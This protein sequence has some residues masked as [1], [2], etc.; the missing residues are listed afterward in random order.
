[1]LR[2]AL[3]AA[4]AL[5]NPVG[6]VTHAQAALALQPKRKELDKLLLR[7]Q[8]EEAQV[9]L[10]QLLLACVRAIGDGAADP[11]LP[12]GAVNRMADVVA[13]VDAARAVAD[14]PTGSNAAASATLRKGIARLA[15]LLSA[16]VLCRDVFVA[17][18]GASAILAS[19]AEDNVAVLQALKAS[20]HGHP[21]GAEALSTAATQRQGAGAAALAGAIRDRRVAVICG[22][23]DV[24]T[25]AAKGV[26]SAVLRGPTAPV[27]T[28]LLMCS[29]APPAV[30]NRAAALLAACANA[31]PKMLAS[32]LTAHHSSLAPAAS[33]I[34]ATC[35]TAGCISG[36]VHHTLQWALA[37]A[38]GSPACARSLAASE[39]MCAALLAVLRWDC[40]AVP[41]LDR[42]VFASGSAIVRRSWARAPAETVTRLRLA[43]R[44]STRLVTAIKQTDADATA[45]TL[46]QRWDGSEDGWPMLTSLLSAAP[47]RGAALQLA[48]VC[49]TA[50]PRCAA[51]LAELAFEAL[52]TVIR[53]G[54]GTPDA[55][56]AAHILLRCAG[57]SALVEVVM[58]CTGATMDSDGSSVDASIG[59]LSL[60]HALLH[61]SAS[62][63]AQC[64]CATVLTA[65]AERHGGVL[66]YLSVQRS[67]FLGDLTR[68]WF[69]LRNGQ[70]ATRE[71]RQAAQ[72]ALDQLLSLCTRSEEGSASLVAQAPSE[73]AVVELVSSLRASRAVHYAHQTGGASLLNPSALGMATPWARHH[74]HLQDATGNEP[75]LLSGPV[76]DPV[77]GDALAGID[78]TKLARYIATLAAK[79]G[80]IRGTVT[81]V[82][83][84]ADRSG[85]FPLAIAASLPDHW[86][87][88]AC[89]H[90]PGAAADL[91]R[92][93]SASKAVVPV[94][95]SVGGR[96]SDTTWT[97][98]ALPQPAHVALAAGCGSI[99]MEHDDGNTS[100]AR[101]CFGNLCA[102]LKS[103]GSIVLVEED[104]NT[105]ACLQAAAQ[106]C[107]LRVSATPE[108]LNSHFCVLLGK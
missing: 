35:S 71:A 54:P 44:L 65:A 88:Y 7:M 70:E 63:A 52:A 78:T 45:V 100:A 86:R 83:A 4:Q 64:A 76:G 15:E 5:G 49:T 39:A 36:A 97:F 55:D 2:G 50:E 62:A 99:L 93:C 98:D 10:E 60:C 103:G 33:K 57:F 8:A 30:A 85:A 108:V 94:D 66:R 25:L 56:L 32:S 14:D 107:G 69:A 58:R 34:L 82:D 90:S 20:A 104:P 21:R 92:A 29:R 37:A 89:T 28:L 43:L 95:C 74:V 106:A 23:L 68:A 13:V 73:Q 41:E 26:C 47:L 51:A 3:S 9:K 31:D 84:F 40:D 6:A 75:V 46:T 17:S 67:G 53:D 38:E 19:L 27:L 61:P 48:S 24:C 22:A 101:L 102:K 1:M 18:G 11:E 96:S 81:L 42:Q 77:L 87:I 72:E 12:E 105:L 80:A 79:S 91:S 16:D 59:V